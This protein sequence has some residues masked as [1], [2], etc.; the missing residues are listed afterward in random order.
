MSSA[1]RSG[2]ARLV[3]VPTHDGPNHSDERPDIHAATLPERTRFKV[4][5]KKKSS[6]HLVLQKTASLLVGLY[7]I[8]ITADFRILKTN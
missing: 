5:Q 8:V 4:A 6:H 2:V 3:I 1:I 7:H